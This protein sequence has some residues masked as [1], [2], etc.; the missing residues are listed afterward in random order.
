MAELLKKFKCKTTTGEIQELSVYT[1]LVEATNEGEARQ[2]K[3]EVEPGNFMTGYIGLTKD[4]D[5]PKAS[6]INLKKGEE[7]WK[8]R[9]YMG[10][11]NFI[12]YMGIVYPDTYQTMTELPEDFSD[13]SDGKDFYSC[14][15]QCGVKNYD[16]DF[17][18]AKRLERCWWDSGA[19]N[20]NIKNATKIEGTLNQLFRDSANLISVTGKVDT[21]KIYMFL[22]TFRYC[23]NLQRIG[24][25]IDLSSIYEVSDSYLYC[26]L[27]NCNSLHSIVFNNVPIGVTEEELRTVTRAPS[28]CQIIMNHRQIQERTPI[29]IIKAENMKLVD[30]D[31]NGDMPIIREGDKPLDEYIV[32]S[33][34]WGTIYDDGA[35]FKCF[36]TKDNLIYCGAGYNSTNRKEFQPEIPDGI[37]VPNCS[38]NI[39]HR[40]TVEN[41]SYL[42][43]NVSFKSWE[44][45][46]IR[47]SQFTTP[48]E[49]YRI[50]NYSYTNDDILISDYYQIAI[51]NA[52]KKQISIIDRYQIGEMPLSFTYGR[53]REQSFSQFNIYEGQ[54][55]AEEL[56]AELNKIKGG[57]L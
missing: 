20:V 53:I 26:F 45:P 30:I 31:V 22:E 43:T 7:H 57:S 28:T 13:T 33:G 2:V 23:S 38:F 5:T 48:Y 34:D 14:F 11:K 36:V 8:M 44:V 40:G 50:N 25:S 12:N 47:G 49:Y 37:E 56:E 46:L 29:R 51:K 19:V 32:N 15:K 3:V 41:Y 1:T 39:E 24:F 9:K 18:N 21:S 35:N 27:S 54:L 17:R 52:Q 16:L 42:M 6:G 4:F 10:I 55:F